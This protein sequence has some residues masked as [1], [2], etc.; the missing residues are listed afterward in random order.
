MALSD[1]PLRS[2]YP[3]RLAHGGLPLAE[4]AQLGIDPAHV[5]D[6]ST[7]LSPLPAHPRVLQAIRECDVHGYP[8][9][10]CSEAKAAIA[11]A[12]SLDSR[13]LVIGH[14]SVELLWSLVHQLSLRDEP[15]KPLLTAS[16]TFSEP[17]AAAR[18]YGIAAV[19]V[20]MAEQTGFAVD[21]DRIADAIAWHLPFAVYLCQPNNPTGAALP[22][23][24]LT[25]LIASHPRVVFI[26]DEAFLSLSELHLDAAVRL[27]P[28][29]VR[30]RSLTKDH[31]LAGLRAGY[32]VGS[33]ELVERIERARPPWMISAPA[34]AAIVVA[35]AALDHVDA[36][37]TE[38]LAHK[39]ALIDELTVL[40]IETVPSRASFLL[41]KVHSA[42][43]LR[44][45]LLSDF[46]VLVRS[47][48]SFGLH[49]HIRLPA[50]LPDARTRLIRALSVILEDA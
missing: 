31:G 26:I 5:L 17:E 21:A 18:A 29:A 28:N 42:D 40:G 19:R 41:A 1:R 39:A 36:V 27:P 23:P 33:P 48:A 20:T 22:R 24:L 9:P 13:G 8:D 15:G 43:A 25:D 49:Q 3:L 34:Q 12:L 7:S 46:G 10:S 4:L 44:A 45:S 6:L 50:C 2:D 14:G 47:C 38:L 30:V 32:A 35:M 16:P 37:R 11:R